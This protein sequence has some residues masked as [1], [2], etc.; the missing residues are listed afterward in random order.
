MAATLCACIASAVSAGTT[1]IPTIGI[2]IETSD[3]VPY[4]SVSR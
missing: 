1:G 3:A 4:A 2:G